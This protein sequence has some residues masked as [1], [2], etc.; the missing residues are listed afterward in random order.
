MPALPMTPQIHLALEGLITEAAAEGLVARV[1]A[2]VRDQ[3][4]ALAEGLQADG[5]LVW[6]LTC[7]NQ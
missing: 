7:A 1:F 4:G 6:L 5:A 2:H 3:I